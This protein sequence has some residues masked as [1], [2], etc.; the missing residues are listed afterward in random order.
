MKLKITSGEVLVGDPCYLGRYELSSIEI[1]DGEYNVNTV[2]LKLDALGDGEYVKELVLLAKGVKSNSMKWNK[3]F[4][5]SV[6][7]G[8]AGFFDSD[9]EQLGDIYLDKWYDTHICDMK[10]Y[11]SETLNSGAVV[12]VAGIGDGSYNV[13]VAEQNGVIVGVKIVYFS[14]LDIKYYNT[15]TLWSRE[16]LLVYHSSNLNAPIYA[17]PKNKMQS[18]ALVGIKKD[19]MF[20]V[21]D[22]DVNERK[23]DGTKIKTE[24]A[25]FSTPKDG[26]LAKLFR[27]SEDKNDISLPSGSFIFTDKEKLTKAGNDMNKLISVGDSKSTILG[28]IKFEAPTGTYSMAVDYDGGYVAAIR[29]SRTK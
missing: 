2:M 12:S 21:I 18:L 4:S 29:I 19:D 8:L 6:D 11:A 3:E 27:L 14:E 24:L 7:S 25:K 13:F 5:I 28:Y 9:T 20:G 16:G 26:R 23:A 10:G 17:V 15:P 22:F 1:P